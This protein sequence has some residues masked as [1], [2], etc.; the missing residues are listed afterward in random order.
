MTPTGTGVDHRI[1]SAVD[2]FSGEAFLNPFPAYA[3]LREMG[4]VIWLE[5]IEAWGVF[6]D[7]I[8]R[9]VVTDWETFGSCGGGGTSN[10]YREEPWRPRSVVFETNPPDH[11][12]TRAVIGR[13][14]SPGAMAELKPIAEAEAER[15]VSEAV[16]RGRFDAMRDL[17]MRF[18]MKVLPDAVGLPAEGRENML[19][20]NAFVRKFRVHGWRANST[21]EELQ[22]GDRIAAWVADHCRRETL[23]PGGYGAQIYD[24]ADAGEITHYEAANLVRSFI[25]AGVET[26]MNA[27]GNTIHL[28]MRHPDQWQRVRADPSLV[29]NAFEE[30]LRF[31]SAIQIVARNTMEDIVFEGVPMRRHDKIIAFTGSANRDPERWDT[32]DVYDVTRRT[33]GHIALGAGIHGCVGQMTARLEATALLGAL[34]RAVERIEPDGPPV[35]RTSGA[36]GLES[37]PVRVVPASG[38]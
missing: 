12:R 38:S 1:S 19:V 8:V 22:E 31:D 17:A 26:T 11:G 28:L 15:M 24:A 18:P 21:D 14:L 23:A 2:L 20:Y 34:V 30:Q 5:R 36:R 4:P 29:R 33:A 6:R 9:R 16:A 32:P 7:P 37:L 3:A 25:T 27:I 35:F 13:V 10:L